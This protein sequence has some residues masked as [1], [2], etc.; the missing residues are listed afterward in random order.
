MS[1]VGTALLNLD[2]TTLHLEPGFAPAE[3]I[4]DNVR[5]ILRGGLSTSPGDLVTAALDAKE[6]TSHLPRRA[7][8]ILDSLADGEFRLRVD[9]I[10]EERLHTVRHR[11]ANRLT[12]GIVIAATILGASL[13]IQVS[14]DNRILGH[15]A[16]AIVLFTV[17][18]LGGGALAAWIVVTDRKVARAPRLSPDSCRARSTRSAPRWTPAVSRTGEEPL[19][20]RRRCGCGRG[21]G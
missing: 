8:R 2:Q 12:L 10:D 19:R 1:M 14:T 21:S 15:P 20:P 16:V 3:G 4:R 6:F 17:A 18:I 5:E 11:V 9:A 13:L 7:N